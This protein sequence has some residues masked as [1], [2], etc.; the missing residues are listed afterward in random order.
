[1]Q[2]HQLEYH[3]QF[4]TWFLLLEEVP[5]MTNHLHDYGIVDSLEP[6]VHT[7]RNLSGKRP[8]LKLGNL[9]QV[10][11]VDKFELAYL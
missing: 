5:M 7:Y 1:M 8:D 9:N 4:Q 10:L 6:S 3:N 11:E 2:H